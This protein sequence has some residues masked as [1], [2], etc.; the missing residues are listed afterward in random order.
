MLTLCG[1]CVNLS[2][3][4]SENLLILF[5]TL[6]FLSLIF[7]IDPIYKR[8]KNRK[9]RHLHRLPKHVFINITLVTIFSAIIAFLNPG[10]LTAALLTISLI[11]IMVLV[12]FKTNSLFLS[13]LVLFGPFFLYGMKGG[14][15]SDYLI[16][17]LFL[18][19]GLGFLA[20]IDFQVKK[21]PF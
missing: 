11:F 19:I 3:M 18:F 13:H 16:L 2:V 15:S 5:I 8:W 4:L 17:A 12:A 9:S 14:L 7:C 6:A 1:L 21:S 10:F 20:F